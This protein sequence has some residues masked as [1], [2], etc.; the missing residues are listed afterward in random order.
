MFVWCVR[1]LRGFHESG[2]AGD[3]SS[4]FHQR[5][6]STYEMPLFG[7]GDNYFQQPLHTHIHAHS[8]TETDILP[9]PKCSHPCGIRHRLSLLFQSRFG[10]FE[11]QL[12]GSHCH[13]RGSSAV[14]KE[15]WRINGSWGPTSLLPY[16][17]VLS[18]SFS[19][20]PK[21]SSHTLTLLSSHFCPILSKFTNFFFVLVLFY[22]L[23]P[24]LFSI[25]SPEICSCNWL[26]WYFCFIWLWWIKMALFFFLFFFFFF[27][28][29]KLIW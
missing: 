29:V 18:T 13:A 10:T 28:P 25:C 16:S 17:A 21:P 1:M 9:S 3:I 11:L 14:T 7:K 8:H 6:F 26:V 23:F 5:Y 4:F 20:P 2:G 12:K 22:S 27:M 24:T 19:L 15:I